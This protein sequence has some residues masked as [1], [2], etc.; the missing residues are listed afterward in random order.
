MG[1]KES[2]DHSRTSVPWVSWCLINSS[3]VGHPHAIKYYTFYLQAVRP[4]QGKRDL[5]T[6]FW[7]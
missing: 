6:P 2:S 7:Y 3:E 4:E 1:E 5:E